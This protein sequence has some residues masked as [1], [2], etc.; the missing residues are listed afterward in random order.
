MHLKQIAQR[1][2][3]ERMEGYDVATNSFVPSAF[4][5]RIEITDRFL[6]NFNKPLR[7]RMLFSA[8]GTVFPASMTFRHPGTQDVYLIGQSRSD[9]LAGDPHIQLSVCHMVTDEGTGSSGLATLTRK[10]AAGPADNPGWLVDQ[11]VTKTFVDMEFRTSSNEADSY[12]LKT[13]SYFGFVPVSTHCEEWDYLTLHGKA[14]RVIDVF[15]D[16]G[17][18]GL[19]VDLE[20]DTRVDFTLHIQGA[21]VYNRA[22]NEYDS[23]ST[24]RNVTG[25]AVRDH[26]FAGWKTSADSYIDIAVETKNIGFRP[27]PEITFVEFDGHKRLVKEVSTQPGERQYLLRCL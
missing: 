13:G 12:E 2:L 20:V 17:L 4:S 9:A 22:T 26:E 1:A 27:E 14:F 25:V 3:N 6:S 24:T 21:R 16:S 11:E 8:P 19:K 10:V 15:P 18:V 7:R 5:G 23:A